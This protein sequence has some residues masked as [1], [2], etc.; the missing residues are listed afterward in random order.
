[1]LA[2]L[3]KMAREIVWFSRR[4]ALDKVTSPEQ[5]QAALLDKPWAGKFHEY[6]EM[7]EEKVREAQAV[8][9]FLK[10]DVSGKSVLDIGPGRGEFLDVC[11][12]RGAARVEFIEYEPVFFTCN[13][14]K[15]YATGV[16]GDHLAKLGKLRGPYDLI[17]IKGSISGAI[18]SFIRKQMAL[19][20]WLRQLDGLCGDGSRIIMCPHWPA[21]Q[22]ADDVSQMRLALCLKQNGYQM[23]PKI[24]EQNSK[25][26]YPVTYMKCISTR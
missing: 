24:P 22:S 1:M 3:R 20:K 26:S 4:Q 25:P 19:R 15:P 12:Q 18:F 7:G 23:L 13:R 9:D 8:L 10:I 14:I 21:G 2:A 17:W 5:F 16:Y 11:H 6:V